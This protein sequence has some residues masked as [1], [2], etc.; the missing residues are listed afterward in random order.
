MIGT[1]AINWGIILVISKNS[2]CRKKKL[3][4]DVNHA[5]TKKFSQRFRI[6]VLSALNVVFGTIYYGKKNRALPGTIS[7]RPTNKVD[8]TQNISVSV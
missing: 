5:V 4:Y 8:T 3:V 6:I 2:S 7:E 1:S